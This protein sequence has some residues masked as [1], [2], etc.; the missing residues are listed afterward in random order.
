[1]AIASV[2]F[3]WDGGNR[4]KCARH[5]VSQAEI[6]A[7]LR[8]NPRVAP[9]VRHS[10]QEDRF[11]AVGR[12]TSGRP[13]FVAFTFRVKAG[14]TLIRPISARYMHGKEIRA[15]EAQGPETDE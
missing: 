12:D 2:G 5:G 4:G 1:M 14:R 9:D 3:D 15:Y 6:E 8:G 11:L 10:H 13:M 7:L